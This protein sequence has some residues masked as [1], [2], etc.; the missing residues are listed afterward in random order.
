MQSTTDLA[1]LKMESRKATLN[2]WI[3]DM[4]NA[5]V[6]ASNKGRMPACGSDVERD[7]VSDVVTRNALLLV[8]NRVDNRVVARVERTSHQQT[9]ANKS[10][11]LSSRECISTHPP[12]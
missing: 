2:R 7:L 11:K 5:Q 3:R 9:G 8:D 10:N 1:G 6:I 4:R 12:L